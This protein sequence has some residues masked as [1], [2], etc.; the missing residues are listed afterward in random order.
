[1]LY[2]A[3]D[4][5]CMECEVPSKLIGVYANEADAMLACDIAEA[6]HEQ[7]GWRDGCMAATEV[8]VTEGVEE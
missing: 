8:F 5:G 3:M 4:L 1:M 7:P 6:S 2:V